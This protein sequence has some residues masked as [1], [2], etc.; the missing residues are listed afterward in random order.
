MERILGSNR[1]SEVGVG[2]GISECG[3]NEMDKVRKKI[4]G[5]RNRTNS[6]TLRSNNVCGTGMERGQVGHLEM[7]RGLE[8]EPEETRKNFEKKRVSW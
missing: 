7:V 1:F 3:R 2:L 8:G 5:K 6:R 4:S